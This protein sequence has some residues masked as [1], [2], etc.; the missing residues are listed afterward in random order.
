[1][2]EGERDELRLRQK[3]REIEARFDTEAR[4]RGFD[5]AQAGNM[6]LSSALARLFT[7]GEELRAEL[8]ELVTSKRGSMDPHAE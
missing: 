2:D 3:L 6:A 8:A 4:K 1:M 5:P 7:E